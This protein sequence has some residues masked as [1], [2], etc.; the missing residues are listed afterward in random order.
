MQLDFGH[1]GFQISQHS[2]CSLDD[3]IRHTGQLCNLN[4]IA[5]IRAAAHDFA[6]ERNVITALFDRDIV[7]LDA[8]NQIFK[9]SQ[10]VIMRCKQRACADALFVRYILYNCTGNAH[11]VI[12]RGAAANLIQNN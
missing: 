11:A 7:I 1:G 9:H 10:F 12:G 2:L 5:V 3:R 6:Q 4:A 8:L